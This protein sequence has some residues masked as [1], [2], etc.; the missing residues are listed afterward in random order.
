[1]S[2]AIQ[3]ALA[4]AIVIFTAYAAGRVHQWYR[5]GFE[6]EVAYREGYNEASHALFHLAIRTLP[7]TSS[8]EPAAATTRLDHTGVL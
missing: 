1:M 8:P 4:V 7:G 3:V 6:R 2:T 5:H